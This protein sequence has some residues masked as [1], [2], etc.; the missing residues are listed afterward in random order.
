[1]FLKFFINV[2]SFLRETECDQGR[3]REKWRHRIR[4]RLQVPSCQHRVRCGAWPH[5]PWDYDL[6]LQ[7]VR[8]WLDIQPTELPRH[9]ILY[10][11]FKTLLDHTFYL[12]YFSQKMKGK[13]KY[14]SSTS[15]TLPAANFFLSY[16]LQQYLYNCYLISV[17]ILFFLFSFK[18][19]NDHQDKKAYW[20]G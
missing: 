14:F 13:N 3:G 7:T 19:Y 6:N 10:Y 20:L 11:Y 15:F 18:S 5:K 16:P 9:P 4:S 12:K 8:F 2:Y 17:S 1:M